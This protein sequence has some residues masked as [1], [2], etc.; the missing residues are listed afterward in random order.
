MCWPWS[1]L[2]NLVKSLREIKT[3]NTVH[4]C[5]FSLGK[6]YYLKEFF[7]EKVHLSLKILIYTIIAKF[8]ILSNVLLLFIFVNSN[9]P[10]ES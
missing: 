1:K 4:H 9:L 10:Q 3:L 7:L 6:P 5:F 8:Q 2:N